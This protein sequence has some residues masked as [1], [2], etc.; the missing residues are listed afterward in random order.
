MRPAR[1]GRLLALL[2]AASA[3]PA[4]AQLWSRVEADGT[5]LV[6]SRPVDERWWPLPGTAAPPGLTAPRGGP[7]AGPGMQAPRVAGKADRPQALLRW[8]AVAPEV[9]VVQPWL[10]EAEQLHGVD[11]D[12][13]KAVIAVESRYQAA[14]VSPRGAIGLMQITPETGERYAPR[15]G[16][17]ADRPVA[18]RLLDARTNILTG[19]RM[20]ADLTRRYGRVDLALVAWNAG[21]GTL[22]RHRLALP[23]IAE[24]QAHVHLVLE[25]YWALLQQ[26]LALQATRLQVHAAP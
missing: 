3:L 22:R 4:Q 13:L 2:L 21:E 9:K 1:P 19:A 16:P 15:A 18:E 11:A 12:L 8:L 10:R 26:R 24:T 23:P 20:L 7:A 25:V 5:A 14:A 6:A 17:A